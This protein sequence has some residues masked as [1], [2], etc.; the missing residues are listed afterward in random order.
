MYL[1][2]E[3]ERKPR[4]RRWWKTQMYK[5]RGGSELMNLKCQ[6][7]SGQYK[8]FDG[9]LIFWPFPFDRMQVNLSFYFDIF[10]RP[11]SWNPQFPARRR[12]AAVSYNRLGL[13]VSITLVCFYTRQLIL[14]ISPRSTF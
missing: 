9:L 6:Q 5:K 1:L 10:L 12:S 3:N 2:L 14:V 11:S 13:L 8:N 7:M 4:K